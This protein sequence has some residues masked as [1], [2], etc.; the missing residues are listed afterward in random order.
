MVRPFKL[1]FVSLL[2]ALVAWASF[3]GGQRLRQ[4]TVGA[5]EQTG[6]PILRNLGAGLIRAADTTDDNDP[7]ETFQEVLRY[8]KS[9]YVDRINDDL[10]L[11]SGAVKTMLQSLDDPRTRFMDSVQKQQFTDQMNGKFT[12]IG[13]ILTVVKQ[14]KGEID[15]RR[16]A[17]ASPVPG[18]PAEKAGIRPGDFITEIDGHWVIAYDPRLDLDRLHTKDP[19][20][21]Q[22][23]Q[24]WKD[25]TKRLTDGLGLQKAMDQLTGNT[26]KPLAITVERS[27]SPTPLKFSII[28][29]T[30]ILNPVQFVPLNN[31]IAYLRVT[32]FNDEATTAFTSALKKDTR[33]LVVLDLRDNAGGAVVS[34]QGG[35]YGSAL[36]LISSLSKIAQAGSILRKGNVQTPVSAPGGQSTYRLAVLVNKGTSNIAELVAAALHDKAGAKLIG[37]GT[38]GDSTFQ[39]LIPL[40]D[41]SAMTIRA[42]KILT[43]SGVDFTGKGLKPDVVVPTGGPKSNGDIAVERA[44]SA[45]SGS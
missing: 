2:L 30:T 6:T 40:R 32:Q 9:D 12:G 44:L 33:R 11:S 28:P 26:S 23:R 24:A 22:Y 18:S 34:V 14:K 41:G 19:N 29:A 16:L 35:V 5:I 7:A 27:G 4:Y 39:K 36:Q 42:G 8:V 10:K 31:R 20:N 17:V 45:L 1:A 38:F 15:Q 3:A 25:A 43:A 37:D 13:T 21:K